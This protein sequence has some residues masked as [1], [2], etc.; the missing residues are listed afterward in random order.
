MSVK[1]SFCPV[2]RTNS[3]FSSVTAPLVVPFI[4]MDAPI[5]IS[6]VLLSATFPFIR[7]LIM[8]ACWAFK[9]KMPKISQR[10]ER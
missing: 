4:E 9:F 5:K 2:I 1:G 3:P 10:M 7:A 8:G 6:F